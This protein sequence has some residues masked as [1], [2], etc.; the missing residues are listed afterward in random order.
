MR[1]WRLTRVARLRARCPC[2]ESR[3]AGSQTERELLALQEERAGCMHAA[4]PGL[5]E[6]FRMQAQMIKPPHCTVDP[7][8][9]GVFAMPARIGFRSTYT[10]AVS[11]TEDPL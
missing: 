8:S 11:D 10:I 7:D 9:S 3:K 4:D 5:T 1:C 6:C 2:A